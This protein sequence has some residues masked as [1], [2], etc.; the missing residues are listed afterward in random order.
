MESDSDEDEE[1]K[2]EDKKEIPKN[3]KNFGLIGDDSEN[4]WLLN[5]GKERENINK[6][7]TQGWSFFLIFKHVFQTLQENW[8]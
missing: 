3:F 6:E 4:P 2:V 1:N 7:E 5:D 8:C